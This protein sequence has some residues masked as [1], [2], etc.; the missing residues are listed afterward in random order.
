LYLSSEKSATIINEKSATLQV[1]LLQ[2]RTRILAC[3]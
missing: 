3:F 2:K 1:E